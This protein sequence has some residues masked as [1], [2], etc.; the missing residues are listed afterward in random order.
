MIRVLPNVLRLQ[1]MLLQPT[2]PTFL[3]AHAVQQGA[4]V[5]DANGKVL[6]E[7]R[8]AIEACEAA[9]GITDALEATHGHEKIC[10]LACIDGEYY[11][12]GKSPM[13]REVPLGLLAHGEPEPQVVGAPLSK[14]LD[15]GT[16]NKFVILMDESL[17]DL[18]GVAPR[19]REA[20][21][22]GAVLVTYSDNKCAH[23]N[24]PSFFLYLRDSLRAS[25]QVSS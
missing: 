24:I 14:C 17:S 1:P 21:G 2:L 19:L 22:D 23:V 18:D 5:R 16:V 20:L 6:L 4:L 3:C 11:C 9:L 25:G 10:C 7:K 12:A 15:L 8:L 13:G